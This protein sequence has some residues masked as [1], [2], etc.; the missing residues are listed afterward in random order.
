M[1]PALTL[2]PCLDKSHLLSDSTFFQQTDAEFVPLRYC[3]FSHVHGFVFLYLF[4]IFFFF[5]NI[6]SIVFMYT[7]DFLISQLSL[8][9]VP[10]FHM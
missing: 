2:L 10:G 3:L 8:R 4:C 7:G 1:S 9:D 5:D 6:F